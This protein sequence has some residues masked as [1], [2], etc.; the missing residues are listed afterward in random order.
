V[1]ANSAT[2]L[3]R[4]KA[5]LRTRVLGWFDRSDPEACGPTGL[6]KNWVSC[7]TYGTQGGKWH[8][9]YPSLNYEGKR[10]KTRNFGQQQVDFAKK[11]RAQLPETGVLEI[12]HGQVMDIQGYTLTADDRFLPD[13]SYHRDRLEYAHLPRDKY[14]ITPLTGTCLSLMT[15]ASDNYCHFLLDALPR[16]HLFE[17][18][19]FCLEDV[20][21]VFV[22]QPMSANAW[23]IFRQLGF[24]ESKCIWAQRQQGIQPDRLIATTHPGLQLHYPRWVVDFMQQRITVQPCQPSRRIYVPR[25]TGTRKIANESELYP[26][27]EKYG[28]ELYSPDEGADQAQAFHEAAFVVAA[29]GAALANLVFCQPGTQVLELMSAEHLQP[30]FFT[31][32][33][34]AGLRHSYIVGP[35]TQPR[36]N[37][38]GL[39]FH[40][41]TID[42]QHLDRALRALL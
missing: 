35:T 33:Q 18:A 37:R 17:K 30:Y 13:L 38:W 11:L 6:A 2:S 36:K 24:D 10:A 26:V 19:G 5:Q 25:P 28:F 34:A 41:F 4:L 27:L 22:H 16:L 3:R 21:W 12:P 39:C 1:I 40:D 8:P 9:V 42:P 7:Q 32:A 31:L 29:H 15:N 14:P 23:K 20:D